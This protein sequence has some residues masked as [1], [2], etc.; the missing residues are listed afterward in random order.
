MQRRMPRVLFKQLEVLTGKSLN[1]FTQR[2]KTLPK[3]RRSAVH[4]QV[5]QFTLGFSRLRLFPQK[6]EFA[7]RRILLYLL[8]PLSP[9]SFG[10]P[11]AQMDK[12][13]GW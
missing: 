7:R 5:P 2:I 9:I 6:L 3:L 10:E 8:I 4:L 13:F 12:V 11:F 1:V